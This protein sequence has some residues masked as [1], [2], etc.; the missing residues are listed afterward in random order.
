MRLK[1]LL[2]Q[3][4]AF[5]SILA[6]TAC[7][8][9]EAQKEVLDNIVADIEDAGT[10]TETPVSITIEG[11]A[12][13]GLISNGEVNVHPIINGVLSTSSSGSG[14]TDENGAFTVS[15]DSYDGNPFVVRVTTNTN[16][17]MKCDLSGGCGGGTSFGDNVPL[18]DS[19]FSLDAILPPVSSSNANVNISVLTHIATNSALENLSASSNPTSNIRNANSSVANRFGILGDLTTLPIVDL[20]NTTSL[21]DVSNDVLK[22]NTISAGIVDALLQSDTSAN[23]QNAVQAFAAQYVN[24]E[25]LADREVTDSSTVTLSEILS[26]ASNIL[27]TIE[28]RDTNGLLNLNNIQAV[29]SDARQVADMGSTEPYS[30]TPVDG[31]FDDLEKAKAMVNDIREFTYYAE[32]DHLEDFAITTVDATINADTASAFEA[33][34]MASEAISAAWEAHYDDDS[35]TSFEDQ[36]TGFTVT[37]SATT[38]STIYTITDTTIEIEGEEVNIGLRAIDT[39]SEAEFTEQDPVT[40]TDGST[41]VV[42][43]G[44]ADIRLNVTGSASNTEITFNI[45]SGLV[46]IAMEGSEIETWGVEGFNEQQQAIETETNMI[47]LT[48]SGLTLALSVTIEQETSASVIDPSTFEGTVALKFEDISAEASEEYTLI[49]EDD[50]VV[51]FA[52]SFTE[53]LTF[54]RMEFSANGQFSKASG[55]RVMAS[56]SVIAT[57]GDL[58]Y[59]CES[60]FTDH[61]EMES[62]TE[63]TADAF[64]P[65]TFSSTVI[66]DTL[67]GKSTISVSAER[68]GLEDVD[69]VVS[70]SHEDMILMFEYEE[71]ASGETITVTHNS[72]A[73]MTLNFS[74]VEG[75]DVVEGNIKINDT[76]YAQIDDEQGLVV[77][78]YND[79]FNE[80]L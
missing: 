70:I 50:T 35:I 6:L 48:V 11:V 67:N 25:G 26:Q 30:G 36:D 59:E 46:I 73:V 21:V 7:G 4:F 45:D 80:T 17:T 1:S 41:T 12:A 64:I 27:Q 39:N 29:I 16:T 51:G 8:T 37:I 9:G 55:E 38:S 53:E 18:T 72:G 68:T 78:R 62:C 23:I 32:N 5:F 34:I 69:P 57:P 44:M 31:N 15:V 74:E 79:G 77:I 63:E 19:S 13:K 33:I 24:D 75:E 60:E 54:E 2:C 66:T 42:T 49:M 47:D 10:D 76:T 14:Q 22:Y 61:S 65:V 58:A 40:N 71:T 52:E 28:S 3:L 56:L 20:T 43:T